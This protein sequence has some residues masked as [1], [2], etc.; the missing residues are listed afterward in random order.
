GY[1]LSQ[2]RADGAWADYVLPVGVADQWVTGYVSTALAMIPDGL[3]PPE[4]SRALTRSSEWLSGTRTFERGWGYNEVAGPDADSTAYALC[5]LRSRGLQP[6]P[7]DERFLLE[8]FLEGGGVRTYLRDDAWGRDHPDV[9]FAAFRALPQSERASRL[10]A[11]IDYMRR[12]RM[13]DGC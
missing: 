9:T 10:A 11:L 4:L 5:F 1:L 13:A 8:H 2:Q 12:M 7:R 3:A 6:E